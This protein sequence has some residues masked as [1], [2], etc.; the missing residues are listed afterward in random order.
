MEAASFDISYLI[1]SEKDL[2]T[3]MLSL[4][5]LLAA[6]IHELVSTQ[7]KKSRLIFQTKSFLY[8]LRIASFDFGQ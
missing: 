3:A 1:T 6:H 7:S 8:R 2:K 5:N 4:V